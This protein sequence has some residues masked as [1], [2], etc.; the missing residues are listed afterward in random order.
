[1]TGCGAGQNG[2]RTLTPEHGRH[3]GRVGEVHAGTHEEAEIADGLGAV[4]ARIRE[5]QP[6]YD[7]HDEVEGQLQVSD[8]LEKASME[9]I[10]SLWLEGEVRRVDWSEG[11]N[12]LLRLVRG[13]HSP[14]HGTAG[15]CFGA[16]APRSGR[17]RRAS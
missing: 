4:P 17:T 1:M 15:P 2:G 16:A 8:R 13:R 10:E 11:S 6:E 12:A 7:P 5:V 9:Y 3:H 14:S